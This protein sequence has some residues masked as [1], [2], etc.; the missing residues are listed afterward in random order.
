[1]A[2]HVH[3]TA[4]ARAWRETGRSTVDTVTLK[5]EG[6]PLMRDEPTSSAPNAAGTA[7]QFRPERMRLVISRR[8][9]VRS[10]VSARIS[11][12]LVARDSDGDTVN[13]VLPV[14]VD[15]PA[16][17]AWAAEIAREVIGRD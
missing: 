14:D 7:A 4:T 5:L 16:W 6:Y 12:D 3:D 15:S 8:G 9:D 10:L 1:M 17:P 11:G 2:A 13:R